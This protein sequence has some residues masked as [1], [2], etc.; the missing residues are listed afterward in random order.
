MQA[1]QVT[2]GG[3]AASYE[4][5]AAALSDLAADIWASSASSNSSSRSSS[6]SGGSGGAVGGIGGLPRWGSLVVV[7]DESVFFWHGASLL[8]ALA[9]A[10]PVDWSG[11]VLV[12]L[13]P[14]GEVSKTR[15]AKAAIEDAMLEHRCVTC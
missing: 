5:R 4:V 12:L 8:S 6:S 7:S 10:A 2:C 1:V 3:A 15:A 11:S 14:P 13:L 9:A